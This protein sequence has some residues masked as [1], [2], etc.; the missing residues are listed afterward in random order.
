MK[1]IITIRR[2]RQVMFWNQKKKE[3][4]ATGN[5]KALR[6]PAFG[7]REITCHDAA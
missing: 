4:A 1:I 2:A 3:K 6:S 5:E 7:G